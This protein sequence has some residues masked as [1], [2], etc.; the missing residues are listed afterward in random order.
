[1]TTIN[2]TLAIATS[3]F[4]SI[5]SLWGIEGEFKLGTGIDFSS[6]D[7]GTDEDTD[8]LYVPV[9]LSYTS[10]AWKAKMTVPWLQIEGPGDVVGGGDGGVVIGDGSGEKTTE[11]GLG[12]IW[13]SVTYSVEAIPSDLL[14]L[15]LV[16]KVKIPTAD[17]DKGL[18]T[19][20][21]DYTLQLDLFKP[22]GKLTPMATVA[23]KIKGSPSEYDL[24]DVFYL[25]LGADYRCNDEVNLGATLDFQEAS[26]DSS[27]DALEIFS[28]LSYRINEDWKVTGYT[29]FGLS[30]GSPDAGGGLSL[31]L[32]M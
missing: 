22:M 11:S 10:G 24:D 18:G 28:Y 21:V 20:E 14:Y 26:S 15:D 3:C 13:T 25:S 7:Y 29:Y 27:D 31:N 8:I 9:N 2:T 30:D 5:G 4:L 32:S 6:G 19:G 17:E 23:Y 1:M 16:G 12:D